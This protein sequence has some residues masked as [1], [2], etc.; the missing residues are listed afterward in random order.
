MQIN[1]NDFNKAQFSQSAKVNTSS[2]LA[3]V[4]SSKAAS[5]LQL[6]C[7]NLSKDNRLE[8][9]N[10]ATI[11]RSIK[12]NGQKINDLAHSSS[13]SN[14]TRRVVKEI[15]KEMSIAKNSWPASKQVSVENFRNAKIIMDQ[16]NNIKNSQESFDLQTENYLAKVARGI[17]N[18]RIVFDDSALYGFD[19]I[20]YQHTNQSL[21]KRVRYVKDNELRKVIDQNF[22]KADHKSHE[23]LN[24]MSKIINDQQRSLSLA[25]D[26]INKFR[27]ALWIIV[28][29]ITSYLFT[30]IPKWLYYFMLHPV[31][32][33][34]LSIMIIGALIFVM[35]EGNNN[36]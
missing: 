17:A 16:L 30:V 23:I 15:Q 1:K 14:N 31:I 26:Q 10:Q 12:T 3:S 32:T 8:L 20:V 5:N 21:K 4:K 34:L 18:Y 19:H 35:F 2:S 29:V 33:L 6:T 27:N 7:N 22:A 11:N 13:K 9:G 25:D 24:K 36:E 28:A